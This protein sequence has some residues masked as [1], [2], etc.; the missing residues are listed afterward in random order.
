MSGRGGA[1]RPSA[2]R[3]QHGTTRHGAGR[4]QRPA[5][6]RAAVFYVAEFNGTP[7]RSDEMDPLW[8][9][10]EDVPFHQMWADDVYWWPLLLRGALFRGVFHFQ[11]THTLVRHELQE[12]EALF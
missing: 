9:A 12:V 4:L 7:M 2:G 8:F 6:A 11:D 3:C 1:A 5:P 10:P